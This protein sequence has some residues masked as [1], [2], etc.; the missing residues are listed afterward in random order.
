MGCL[1]GW[2]ERRRHCNCCDR[3]VRLFLWRHGDP[4]RDSTQIEEQD[5]LMT[6]CPRSSAEELSDGPV[7]NAAS[8]YA[9]M[10]CRRTSQQGLLTSFLL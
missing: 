8:P 6:G 7:V 5:D 9:V 1:V 4:A 3:I 2:G 10:G